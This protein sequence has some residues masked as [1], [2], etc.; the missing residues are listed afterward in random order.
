MTVHAHAE[1]TVEDARAMRNLGMF[2]GGFVLF[3]ALLAV[4]VAVLA[5]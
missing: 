4:G 5:P 1:D 2:V 3:A